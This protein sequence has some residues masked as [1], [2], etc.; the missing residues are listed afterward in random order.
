MINESCKIYERYSNTPGTTARKLYYC[1]Q[2]VGRFICNSDFYIERENYNSILLIYTLRGN[3]R[4]SYRGTEYTVSAHSIALINCLD[5]HVYFP[6]ENSE[7]DFYFIHFEGQNC[8]EMY[9]YLYSLNKGAVFEGNERIQRYTERCI[10]A[11][12][13]KQNG[14]EAL[15]SMSLSDILHSCITHIQSRQEN[16]VSQICEYVDE[17]FSENVKT[18]ELAERFGFSRCYFSTLFKEYTGKTVHEYLLCCRLDRAKL[19]LLEGNLSVEQIAQATGFADTGTFIRAF[20][21]KE[22]ITPTQY[23]KISC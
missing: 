21:R 13:V 22:H 20:K 5:R 7:W 18:G 11:C 23:R 2:F 17:H 12:A 4:L 19:M 14:Y 6:A 16:A 15:M 9:E 3:A 10:N 1:P 8:V